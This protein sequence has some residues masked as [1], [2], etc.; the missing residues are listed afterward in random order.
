MNILSAFSVIWRTFAHYRRYIAILVVLGF[1]GAF[2]EGIGINAAIP[3][4]S[5]LISGGAPTDFIS[6]AVEAGF[7]FVRIPFTFRYLLGFVIGLF[8]LRAVAQVLFGYVRGWISA[9][10]LSTKSKSMLRKTLFASWPFLLRQKLGHVQHT[11]V[12]EV[13][14]AGSLLE[15]IGQAIQSFTGFFMYLLIALNIS[16]TVT[17]SALVAGG[18]L[19]FIVRPLVRRIHRSVVEMGETEKQLSHFLSENILGMK[20]IKAGG[21]EEVTYSY[22]QKLF[23]QLRDLQIRLVLIKSFS[24]SFFQPFAILFVIVLFSVSYKTPGFSFIAFAAS[25]YLIQKVFVYLES[26]QNAIN[27]MITL[28]PY[29]RSLEQFDNLLVEHQEV[30]DKEGEVFSFEH[31]IR[32]D[33]VSLSY[34][35]APALV[36]VSFTIPRGHTVGLIGPSGA[37]KTTIAD[38]LLRLFEPTAGAILLDGKPLSLVRL[39][40]WRKR[41]GYVAQDAFLVNDTIEENIRF[42]YPELSTEDIIAAAKQANIYDFIV[43]LPEGFNTMVGDRGVMLSGGQ[44]QRIVLARALARRPDLLILDEATSA[45]DAE[46]ERLIQEAIRNLSGTVTVFIIAHRLSTIEHADTILVIKEGRI[47]EQGSPAELRK[48]PHSYFTLQSVGV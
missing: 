31:D 38:L 44:R 48:N 45:L 9:Q 20:V 42:Y 40:E 46:S 22:S 35:R 13:Q 11:L 39:N 4:M 5:F 47:C 37:G 16:V 3:L 1:F 29:V 19:L 24:T 33:A 8:I 41:I 25:L 32:F 28:L 10:F 6:R 34:Q 30:A 7:G 12:R 36:D 21:A 27:S 43:E 17:L 14:H 15:V 2:L 23:N 18:G 26:G